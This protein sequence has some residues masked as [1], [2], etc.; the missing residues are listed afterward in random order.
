MLSR[1][2]DSA[3][4]AGD[5][6]PMSLATAAAAGSNGPLWSTSTLT[7]LHC[8]EKADVDT[9]DTVRLRLPPA[10]STR[11]RVDG[12][13]QHPPPRSPPASELPSDTELL[14]LSMASLVCSKPSPS[15]SPSAV[16]LSVGHCRKQ[17]LA[18]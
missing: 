17:R 16:T 4:D 7:L 3:A 8:S 12:D 10:A 1:L 14:S 9:S 5:D 6:R 13:E 18:L 15:P 2:S 11:L